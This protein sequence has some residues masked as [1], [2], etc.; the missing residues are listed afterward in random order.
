[1]AQT[2]DYSVTGISLAF[3]DMRHQES[4]MRT[5]IQFL[6]GMHV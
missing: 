2:S 4:S 3:I 1:M 6:G 5:E